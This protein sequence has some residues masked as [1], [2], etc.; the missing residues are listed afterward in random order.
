MARMAIDPMPPR[1]LSPFLQRPDA[2]HRVH[3]AGPIPAHSAKVY[4]VNTL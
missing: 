4:A 1:L 2:A 3:A